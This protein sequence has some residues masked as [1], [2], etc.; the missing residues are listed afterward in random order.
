MLEDYVPEADWGE[1]KYFHEN[2]IYKIFY[3]GDLSN[4]YD[5]Y[6]S[7]EILYGSF[8]KYYDQNLSRSPFPP[9]FLRI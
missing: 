3:G 9:F 6:Y 7:F 2:K 5:Y 1:I 8:K 4:P